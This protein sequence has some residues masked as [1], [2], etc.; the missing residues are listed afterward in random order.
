MP[1]SG[2]GIRFREGALYRQVKIRST[3]SAM[4]TQIRRKKTT[5]L[6]PS[7]STESTHKFA[8]LVMFGAERGASALFGAIFAQCFERVL[9]CRMSVAIVRSVW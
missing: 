6:G 4:Y 2:Y 9:K 8:D 7:R 5:R 3:R 1:T